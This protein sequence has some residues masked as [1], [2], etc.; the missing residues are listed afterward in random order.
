MF[1]EFIISSCYLFSTRILNNKNQREGMKF[2]KIHYVTSLVVIEF[3][4]KEKIN[5]QSRFTS[6]KVIVYIIVVL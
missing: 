1:T 4:N 3:D 2:K 5:N 6:K